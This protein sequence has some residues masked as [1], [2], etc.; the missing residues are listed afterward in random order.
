MQEQWKPVREFE[1]VYEVSNLGR[2]R[3]IK[4]TS[5]HAAGEFKQTRPMLR[6]YLGVLLKDKGRKPKQK[7]LHIMVAE[8]FVP[9]PNNLPQVNHLG[10]KTDCR[11]SM[12]EWRSVEG[13][14]LDA[15]K[16][17]LL[18]KGNNAG[19]GLHESGQWYARY[20]YKRKHHWLGLFTT[21]EEALNV[22]RTAIEA[23]PYV[24]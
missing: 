11:S 24:L 10:P 4:A 18:G 17:G 1:D 7:Y 9:N 16:R 15:M 5:G 12:L 19:V 6:G 21:K 8:A 20:W 23:L 3:R 2:L 22:R 14:I 13:N